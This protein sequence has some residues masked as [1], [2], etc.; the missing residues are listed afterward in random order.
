MAKA[1]EYVVGLDV[2]TQS[3][4][5]II[6]DRDGKMVAKGARP[7]QPHMIRQPGWA[8]HP[9]GDLWNALTG[10]CKDAL[11]QFP[12]KLSEIKAFGLST[13]RCTRVFVDKNG[14]FIQPIMS[15]LDIRTLVPHQP[16]P[17]YE[18]L[19]KLLTNSGYDCFRLTGRYADTSGNLSGIIYP[20]SQK[21]KDWI[22]DPVEFS[23]Y[24]LTKDQLPE[25]VDPGEVL[26]Y[27]TP[28]AAFETGLPEGLPVIAGAGDKQVEVLGAGAI[29]EGQAYIT[30]GTYAGFILV[31]KEYLEDPSLGCY[32]A[33]HPGAYHYEGYGVR[34]GFWN[35]SWF[36]RNFGCIAKNI[37]DTRGI[38]CEAALDSMAEKVPVGCEGLMFVPDFV[39]PSNEYRYRR[40]GFLG[41]DGRH[42]AAHMYRSIL[43]G[44]A[45]SLKM[46]TDWMLNNIKKDVSEIRIGGGG[47]NS[48]VCMQIFADVFGIPVVR[49]TNPESCALGA[50]IDAAVGCG[51]YDNFE[52]AVE[53]M[54]HVRD[55]FE[56]YPYNHKFYT[57]LIDEVY[58]DLRPT[59][60]PMYSKAQKFWDRW[61]KENPEI[62]RHPAS[63]GNQEM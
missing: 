62:V 11:A 50:A 54:V 2:G 29:H 17:D 36:A 23:K 12:G 45:M 38:P 8:E 9:M 18:G 37:M 28:Q 20:F 56:P 3:T 44:I 33:P 6:F 4:R 43:E 47:S 39:P 15:W 52:D 24:N 16:G 41:L 49:T 51:M 19:Y 63:S 55:T 26:G 22:K 27:L 13:Q 7:H 5:V 32:I 42:T 48:T 60:D 58:K 21:T 46:N 53:G 57:E 30:C 59:T 10:A 61:D 14:E 34:R 40:G 1:N 25:L 35:I 31:G